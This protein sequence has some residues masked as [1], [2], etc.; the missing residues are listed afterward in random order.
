MVVTEQN[1]DLFRKNQIDRFDEVNL[2]I[3]TFE[4]LGNP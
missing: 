4:D 1:F 2:R 3:K